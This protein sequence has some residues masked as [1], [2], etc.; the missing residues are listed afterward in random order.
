[1]G[2]GSSKTKNEKNKD[3]NFYTFT[4]NNKDPRDKELIDFLADRPT[5]ASVKDGLR[6]LMEN[7]KQPQNQSGNQNIIELLS[8]LV[9]SPD[10]S[11]L[12]SQIKQNSGQ[13]NNEQAATIETT[14]ESK[15]ESKPEYTEEEKVKIKERAGKASAALKNY[16]F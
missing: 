16:D 4:L 13:V 3:R 10:V 7:T 5:T 11:N 2:K 12:L 9:N 15:Q 6:L 14:Q 1:M 8:L